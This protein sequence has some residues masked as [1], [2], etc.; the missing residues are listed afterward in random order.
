MAVIGRLQ[1]LERLFI[2][3]LKHLYKFFLDCIDGYHYNCFARGDRFD[4]KNGIFAMLQAYSLK[5]KREAFFESHRKYV[6]F[7]LTIRGAECF[8]IG[9]IDDFIVKSPYDEEKD[10]TEYYSR[11][12]THKIL[13]LP[14]N[15]CIFTP[16]DVHAGGLSNS[17]LNGKFVHKIVAKIPLNLIES[18]IIK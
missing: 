10:Y 11:K 8:M 5:P 2:G 7:Q 14:Q 9:D 18:T 15:L 4:L 3:D 16:N 12:N 13:S 6:D 17:H 1:K